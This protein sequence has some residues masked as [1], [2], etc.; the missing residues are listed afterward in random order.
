M[1]RRTTLK[2]LNSWETVRCELLHT[3]ICDLGIDIESSPVQNYL[4]RLY[5]EM[6]K[7]GLAYQPEAYLTDSWGCPDRVPVIGVPFYLA[8]RR[9]ARIEEEQTGEIES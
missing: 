6:E 9:L 4:D 1:S 8:D 3:R 5:R 2:L 7:K